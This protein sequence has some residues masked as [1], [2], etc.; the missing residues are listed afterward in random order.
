MARPLRAGEAAEIAAQVQPR[1]QQ[2]RSVD[3]WQKV[4]GQVV[5]LPDVT[6]VTPVAAGPASRSA[7][8]R[9]NR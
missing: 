2:L 6:G 4:R 7:A 5:Q 8:K 9:P 3:Q 1:S